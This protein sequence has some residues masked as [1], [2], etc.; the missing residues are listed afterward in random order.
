[1]RTN[2]E[3]SFAEHITQ[4]RYPAT[5]SRTDKFPEGESLG[6]VATRAE[7]VVQEI[8]LP[9]VRKA[10]KEGTEETHVALVSH[11]IFI[12]EAIAALLRKNRKDAER[13]D[14]RDYHGLRNTGWTQVKVMAKV[15]NC[16]AL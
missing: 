3:I 13:I 15:T 5:R 7:Q 4:G 10:A 1:M 6:E 12:A 11:G 8:I 14:A 16:Q 2:P 9:Y